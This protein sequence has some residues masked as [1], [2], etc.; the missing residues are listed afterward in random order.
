MINA[1]RNYNLNEDLGRL[2]SIEEL[3][4]E[5]NISRTTAYQRRL[6][7]DFPPEIQLSERRIVFPERLFREWLQSRVRIGFGQA[8]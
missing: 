2:M 4:S 5:L 8:A 7:G 6:R 3:C 1:L